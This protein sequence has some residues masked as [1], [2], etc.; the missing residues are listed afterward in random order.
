M[1]TGT[2]GSVPSF[3]GF[4]DHIRGIHLVTGPGRSVWLEPAGAPT[5]DPAFARSFS[6]E[7]FNRD[8]WFQAALVHLGGVGYVNAVL[9]EAAPRFLVGIVQRKRILGR[10]V[11]DDLAQGRFEKFA[12][13]LG[14]PDPYFVQIILNPFRPNTRHA[15][16]RLLV[17][18]PEVISLVEGAL[19]EGIF[20]FDPL[21]LLGDVMAMLP[22]GAR[23][24]LIAI[25]MRKLYPEIPKQGA[26]PTGV[27]WGATTPDHRR[28]GDLFST[29]IAIERARL[30]EALDAMLPAFRRKDG[31]D[32]VCTLRFVRRSG[33]T[34]AITPH[35]DNVVID[36][37]GLRSKASREAYKRVLGALDAAGI[38]SRQHWGKLSLLDPKRVE[39]DHGDAVGRWKTARRELLAGGMADIFRSRA[40]VDWGL[41]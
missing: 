27:T 37:D 33:G 29:A 41:A 17:P 11:I 1:A 10:D 25:L 8:D 24:E 30:P 5:L 3:G 32:T 16:I 39:R 14:F 13:S 21:N 18:V 2:H 22:P 7:A 23:G 31:G 15:L 4:Q 6:N 19:F 12:Q 34:L 36:F 9:L 40:L 20:D 26:Q 28:V 38:P 35:A